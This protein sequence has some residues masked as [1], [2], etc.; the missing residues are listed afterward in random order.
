MSDLAVQRFKAFSMEM[1][2][3]EYRFSG[4]PNVQAVYLKMTKT[5]LQV[6]GSLHLMKYGVRLASLCRGIGTS[7]PTIKIYFNHI[8]YLR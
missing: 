1:T 4:Y 2:N 3:A 8:Q 6:A 5:V 7:Y